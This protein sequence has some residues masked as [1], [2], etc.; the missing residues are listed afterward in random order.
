VAD[1]PLYFFKE[2]RTFY[3]AKESYNHQ[4]PVCHYLKAITL[5]NQRAISI[6]RD[7]LFT[8]IVNSL[9]FTLPLLLA[10]C[11]LSIAQGNRQSAA[12][13]DNTRYV[14]SAYSAIAQDPADEQIAGTDSGY[15]GNALVMSTFPDDPYYINQWPLEKIRAF[16][17]QPVASVE[18]SVITV[19]VLDTGIDKG[20]EDLQGQVIAEID[21]TGSGS[22]EDANGHG[23]HIAGIIAANTNNG[24]GIAGLAPATKL[25][26]VK[27]AD[28]K[29][30]CLAS[31]VAEGIIWAVDHGALVINMSLELRNPTSELENAVNYAWAKGAVLVAA[32][33]NENNAEPVYPA[34][35][36]NCLSAVATRSNDTVGPLTGYPDWI[37]VAAPGFNVFSTLPD[38]SYGY[39]SGT[40]FATAYVS[41]LAALL[42]TYVSDKNGD[43]RLNDEVRTAIEQG[44]IVMGDSGIKRID[45]SGSFE[46][47]K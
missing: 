21:L 14:S 19:A 27:V 9:R 23:T 41:G 43:N 45:V 46:S 38:D 26:N 29:G 3:N 17:N 8:V 6:R 11:L 35:F 18:N 1:H 7:F 15:T 42:F 12:V 16:Q 31:A 4:W 10:V 20:H 22:P 24:T 13:E 30:R 25:L 36:Q 39:K 34:Y 32:A 37:D 28:K 44:A 2:L 33:S 40:S 5:Y 47:I